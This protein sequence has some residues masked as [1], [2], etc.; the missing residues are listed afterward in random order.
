CSIQEI[1]Q[2][3]CELEKVGAEGSVIRCFPLSRLF[4]MCPGL[5]AVEVTTVLNID[6]NGAVENP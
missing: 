6:E 3:S 5:P 2:Y 1:V 4:K